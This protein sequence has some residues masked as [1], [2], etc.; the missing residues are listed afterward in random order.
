MKQRFLTGIAIVAVLLLAILMRT[1]TLYAFDV[2]VGFVA[3]LS[4]LEM[5]KMLAK[6]GRYNYDIVAAIHI[7]LTYIVLLIGLIYNI[8]L[9]LI[10]IYEL[11]LI[12]VL[13]AGMFVFTQ[14]RRK[15]TENEIKTRK[16]KIG[17]AKFSLI[18]SFNTLIAMIYPN[19]LF[20]FMIFLNHLPDINSSAVVKENLMPLSF[21]LIVLLFTLPILTDTFAYLTGNLIGGKKLCPKISPKKTISGAVGGLLWS[22]IGAVCIFLI[23]GAFNTYSNLFVSLNLQ[24]WHFAIIG[25]VSAIFCIAGDLFESLLKRVASVK[26]SGDIFPGH[27]GFLDRF[28]SHLFN[29]LVI[30]VVSLIILI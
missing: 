16:L 7:I 17:N 5:T 15:K 21:V 22:V 6:M 28:D 8:G 2:L 19:I 27:G 26:D 14:L 12:A 29:A 11:A 24:F 30:L 13:F 3:V 1:I 25:F 4:L 10:L 9:Y 20:M 23:F 18:K